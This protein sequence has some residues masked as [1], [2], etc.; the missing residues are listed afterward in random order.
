MG[1]QGCNDLNSYQCRRSVHPSHEHPDRHSGLSRAAECRPAVERAYIE[2]DYFS[3]S[4]TVIINLD[5]MNIV[6]M[7]NIG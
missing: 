3:Q 2:L 5:D 7:G 6:L 4:V 1:A